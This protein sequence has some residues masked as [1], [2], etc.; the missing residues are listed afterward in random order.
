M[1]H[2]DF[3]RRI[4]SDEKSEAAA[5]ADAVASTRRREAALL[6]EEEE[7]R[8]L[9]RRLAQEQERQRIEEEEQRRAWEEA[10]QQRMEA[11]KRKKIL[12]R[13]AEMK[14]KALESEAEE[15][16]FK[17]AVQQRKKQEWELRRMAA[18]EDYQRETLA[19]MDAAASAIESLHLEELE[20]EAQRVADIE[21][22]R[23]EEIWLMEREDNGSSQVIR[24]EYRQWR[25]AE[26]CRE[27]ACADDDSRRAAA[28]KQATE[29][30]EE[31]RKTREA[32]KQ[33]R[34]QIARELECMATEDMAS[35]TLRCHTQAIEAEAAARKAELIGVG[36]RAAEQAARAEALVREQAAFESTRLDVDRQQMAE[37]DS[38]SHQREQIFDKPDDE[39]RAWEKCIAERKK[40]ERKLREAEARE[41]QQMFLEDEAGY[42]VR[43][44]EQQLEAERRAHDQFLKAMAEAAE[45]SALEAEHARMIAEQNRIAN[46]K[47]EAQRREAAERSAM[48]TEDRRGHEIRAKEAAELMAFR[49]KC[50]E[51]FERNQM[52]AEDEV[53]HQIEAAERRRRAVIVDETE[54]VF[55]LG[56]HAQKRA[57]EEF[58]A[59]EAEAQAK[60]RKDREE[61]AMRDEAAKIA[62]QRLHEAEAQ[63]AARAAEAEQEAARHEAEQE[64]IKSQRQLLADAAR[65]QALLNEEK[66]AFDKIFQKNRQDISDARYGS[67]AET[68]TFSQP[69]TSASHADSSWPGEQETEMHRQPY[70]QAQP[71]AAY[72]E[73]QESAY[74]SPP[75]STG[76]SFADRVKRS[77]V[78]PSG[79]ENTT[80]RINPNDNH[81][82]PAVLAM[83]AVSSTAWPLDYS[84]PMPETNSNSGHEQS[85]RSRPANANLESSIPC[86]SLEHSVTSTSSVG[87]IPRR[88]PGRP[89]AQ[90]LQ[91]GAP[92]DSPESFEELYLRN[93]RGIAA[94][95]RQEMEALAS[96]RSRGT[97]EVKHNEADSLQFRHDRSA[98]TLPD[99]TA[100]QPLVNEWE[101]TKPQDF[102]LLAQTLSS[103]GP[104]EQTETDF[105][106]DESATFMTLA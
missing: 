37:E 72:V 68:N 51:E 38:M 76:L 43:C 26:E 52:A 36:R 49:E 22:A 63:A 16:S 20:E 103:L 89:Q 18:E 9:A 78:E 88:P 91:A 12:E 34:Q 95:R 102:F 40:V 75:L 5:W 59:Q 44:V 10:K 50:F 31:V 96:K 30:A 3:W 27:M 33:E 45:A 1:L 19:R 73:Q 86:I 83:P 64:Y 106:L 69:P 60:A 8:E 93:R 39:R 11:L 66:A 48:F 97:L 99:S 42:V 53:A 80:C 65:R 29:W 74:S 28:H 35:E 57:I 2:P 87:P 100:L 90:A 14:R 94:R 71:Q 32:L 15:C 41:T 85:D 24:E 58:R 105:D 13:Q 23:L 21:A 54:R 56:V 62:Q 77:T 6:A 7:K 82:I 25:E 79:V 70:P 92:P 81:N 67:S 4:C 17:E 101:D 61:R 98:R 84:A 46:E 55:R 47:R 104:P